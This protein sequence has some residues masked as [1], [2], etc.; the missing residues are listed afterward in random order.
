MIGQIKQIEEARRQR[1]EEAPERGPHAMVRRLARVVGIGIETA[2]MLFKRCC[3]EAGNCS[4]D[5]C[6][7]RSVPTRTNPRNRRLSSAELNVRI[8][9]APAESQVK[10]RFLSG[11]APTSLIL[12]TREGPAIG[13]AQRRR[14]ACSGYP[15]APPARPCCERRS[16]RS[17]INAGGN[18][19]GCGPH[20]RLK[21]DAIP[22]QPVPARRSAY[23]RS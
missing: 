15:A 19:A 11:G 7:G 23:L 5:R 9:S 8:H 16:V 22:P 14:A 2:D 17:D 20:Q 1:L 4:D 3:A 12:G 13:A 21:H 10:H 18:R 6:A